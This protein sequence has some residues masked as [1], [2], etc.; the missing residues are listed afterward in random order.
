MGIF[1]VFFIYYLF[2]FRSLI[3][4]SSRLFLTDHSVASPPA[5]QAAPSEANHRVSELSAP[6]SEQ[7]QTQQHEEQQVPLQHSHTSQQ[8]ENRVSVSSSLSLSH[9]KQQQPEENIVIL[10]VP[11]AS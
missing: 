1:F 6:I 3:F 9:Q 8:Q 5:S 10:A 4:P 11:S 7:K 2:I